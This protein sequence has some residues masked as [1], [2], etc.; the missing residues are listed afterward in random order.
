MQPS[1]ERPAHRDVT[2]VAP[3]DSGQDLNDRPASIKAGLAALME[4][5][6]QTLRLQRRSD[7][8]EAAH[9][10][11]DALY[12]TQLHETQTPSFTVTALF[13]LGVGIRM[14]VAMLA[15]YGVMLAKKPA[16]S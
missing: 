2:P 7:E 8:L 16:G 15:V 6:Y 14:T 4:R 9:K 12:M 11:I 5:P 1:S 3:G 13:V 10:A